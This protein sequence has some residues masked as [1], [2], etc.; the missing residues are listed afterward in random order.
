MKRD[1]QTIFQP[2][3][4]AANQTIPAF[5]HP[6]GREVDEAVEV[7]I[8]V[9]IANLTPFR[10]KLIELFVFRARN[11]AVADGV[12]N[13]FVDGLF[14]IRIVAD[15]IAHSVPKIPTGARKFCVR[16]C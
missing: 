3:T 8:A 16:R 1:G 9:R 6:T 4:A 11:N 12:G 2:A 14:R 15:E 7:K 13:E 5:K 10:K